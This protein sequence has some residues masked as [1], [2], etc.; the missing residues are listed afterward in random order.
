MSCYNYPSWC[1]ILCFS[2]SLARVLFSPFLACLLAYTNTKQNGTLDF[3]TEARRQSLL[4]SLHTYTHV[5]PKHKQGRE[6]E[7]SAAGLPSQRRSNQQPCAFRWRLSRSTALNSRHHLSIN[8]LIDCRI[9]ST[10][11]CISFL[12]WTHR[13]NI[14]TPIQSGDL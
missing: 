11:E 9:L 5:K 7:M 8:I 10:N 6:G 3:I 12:A 13:F 2:Y 4:S 14:G 1:S